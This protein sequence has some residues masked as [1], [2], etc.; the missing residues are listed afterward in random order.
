MISVLFLKRR[1]I[2]QL[3]F[4]PCAALSNAAL[5][6]PG[7][8]AVVVNRILV[9]VGP[10]SVLSKVTVALV[11]SDSGGRLEVGGEGLSP[12]GN[13]PAWSSAI[14]S[15]GLVPIPF[16]NRVPNEYWLSFNTPLWVE[17]VPLPSF[18][19]PCHTAL[20]VRSIQTPLEANWTRENRP[21]S[22]Y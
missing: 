12:M 14:S 13:K 19:P 17:I 20:A 4:A 21:V 6:A 1:E 3:V 10:A 22:L 2:G 11:S 18:R 8:L 9:I 5:S 15:S 16:S 7:T